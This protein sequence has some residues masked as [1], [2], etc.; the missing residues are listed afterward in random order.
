MGDNPAPPDVKD[1]SNVDNIVDNSAENSK[2]LTADKAVTDKAA[3]D[4]AATDKT[5]ISDPGPKSTAKQDPTPETQDVNQDIGPRQNGEAEIVTNGNGGGGGGGGKL[6]ENL[7]ESAEID[8]KGGGKKAA[9]NTK[10]LGKDD[11]QIVKKSPGAE[12]ATAKVATGEDKVEVAAGTDEAV[13]QM[14]GAESS[15]EKENIE[16]EKVKKGENGF[17]E[18]TGKPAE[19]PAKEDPAKGKEEEGDPAE[20]VES[21]AKA[22]AETPTANATAAPPTEQEEQKESEL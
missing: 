15:E 1:G 21:V 14:A 10:E 6:E 5:P 8:V 12:E 7:E 3:T 22:K 2:P 9:E 13:V 16:P 18:K 4:K 19:D 17:A 20:K 11:V